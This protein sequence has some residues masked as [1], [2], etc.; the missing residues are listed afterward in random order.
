MK[1]C[2]NDPEKLVTELLEGYTL[3]FPDK[4]KLLGENLVMRAYPKDLGKVALV[5]LGGS[6]HEPGLS[7]FVGYGMLDVSV[8]G[9]IF[10]A[11]GPPK[12]L[13][14]F[15]RADRGGGV[16]FVVLNHAGDVLTA[17]IT[18]EMALEAYISHQRN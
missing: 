1:K 3:A 13:N 6:G 17:N 2:I 16:L 8:P 4:V 5:T 12:C 18:M 7:G 10:A 15:K 9:E 11:P 14:A